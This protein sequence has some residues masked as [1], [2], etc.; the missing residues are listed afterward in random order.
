MADSM[1][2]ASRG[3]RS[4]PTRGVILGLGSAV[5]ITLCL[6]GLAARLPPDR[7]GA[8]LLAPA[9]DRPDELLF[10]FGL[11]PRI[12]VSLL[13]GAALGLSGGLLSQLLRNPLAE[14]STLGTSAGAALALS[15]TVL[16][17]PSL[18]EHGRFA[19]ALAGSLAATGLVLA[20]SL[21]RRLSPLAVV[22]AGLVVGLACGAAGGMIT[23]FDH[24]YLT[25]LLLW[26]AGNLAQNGWHDA[27]IL[28]VL[29]TAGGAGAGA[30]A[31][32]LAMLDLG[33]EGARSLGLPLLPLRLAILGL[34]VALAAG[35]AAA[36]GVIGFVGLMA[37]AIA[38]HTGAGRGLPRLA[39]SAL[40]GA[41]LLCL[42]DQ[43]GQWAEWIWETDIPAGVLTT[44]LGAPLLL[45]M[46]PRLGPAAPSQPIALAPR[47]KAPVPVLAF[48]GL[49]AI[50]SVAL[51]LL[52]GRADEG[53][54]VASL[55]DPVLDLRAPRVAAAFASGVL[56]AVAGVLVQRLSGNPM[57]S[58][59][60]TGVSSGA[61]IGAIAAALLLPALDRTGLLVGAGAGA[62]AV[63]STLLLVGLRAAFSP[64]RLLLAGVALTTMAGAVATLVLAAGH[65][66]LDLV[67]RLMAGS[68]YFVTPGEATLSL[69]AAAAALAL[70]VAAARP[71]DLLG[72]GGPSAATLGLRL[73]RVRL[74]L[75]LGISATTAI[76]TLVVGPLSFAGLLA[77]H[78]ARLLGLGRPRAQGL[79]AALAGGAL[80]AGADLAGRTIAFP[81]QISAGL[82]CSLIGAPFFLWLM[83]RRVP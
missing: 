38:R 65:P 5:A 43:V 29:V 10:H 25:A 11:L 55:S 17:A 62:V 61:G 60:L 2:L 74:F 69:V 3:H 54:D 39:A 26:Q 44:L 52:V 79:G 30:L 21:G 64:D 32:A 63:A 67:M 48:L 70:L 37:P 34:A 14:P 22:L 23:L 1:S 76:A 19:V 50:T 35:S 8:A 9:T 4:G 42:A 53:W 82:L 12:V 75:L 40:A 49:L 81:W 24:Q 73:G 33:D 47:R 58:P 18:L 83:M 51:A 45:L 59:E 6:A 56:L 66:R 15:A 46:L 80:M 7:W 20:I 72:L 31:R 27:L 41:L 36:A 16:F 78:L 77:P 13:V 68:T 57:A 28:A 71:I